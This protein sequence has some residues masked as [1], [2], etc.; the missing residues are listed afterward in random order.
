MQHHIVGNSLSL[1]TDFYQ[2]TMAYGYWKSGMINMESAFHMFYRSPPFKSRFCIACGL[3]SLLEFLEDFKYSS[4]DLN[5]LSGIKGT[6]QK[7]IFEEG[8]IRYLEKF[9]F[10][11]RIDAVKE[12]TVVFP[13]EP[14]LRVQGSLIEGQLLET[15]ILNIINFQTLI[16]TKAYRISHAAQDDP[17]LEFGLRRAQGIDG[18]LSASRAAYIGGCTGTSNVLAGKIFNIPIS[19]TMAH[20]WIMAFEDEL[21]A[22]EVYSAVMPNNCV[23]LVDTYS[24]LSGVMNAIEAGKKLRKKGYQLAAIRLDSG[25][26]AYL[27]SEAR[28]R[29]DEAGFE[30]V[31]IIVSNELDEQL[32]ESLKMQDSKIDAWGVGTKLVTATGHSALNG[33]YKLSAI[34][35]NEEAWQ[36]RIKL[37]EQ[38]IKVTTPGIQQVR[39]YYSEDYN[40]G[41][42]IYNEQSVPAKDRVLMVDPMDSTKRK[43]FHENLPY[44]N[45]L[46]P[47]FY[48]GV[49][50][51]KKEPL[52]KIRDY[53]KSET[54]FFHPTIKRSLN[55]HIYPVGL[56]ESLYDLKNRLILNAREKNN[57]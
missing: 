14:I 28:K 3:G 42:M 44:K 27:S 13:Y 32:I 54:A 56:E 36:Y 37:S 12:G 40:I 5:Y 21:Q 43:T 4:S 10:T 26:L 18:A 41:D 50:Q 2:L 53:V 8:F 49:S 45:L 20:S 47:F 46:Q 35:K 16:A 57:T 30:Q 19:G 34:R 29:L 52:S 9:R 11:S 38:K 25:D 31:K 51:V 7:P 17:V 6:D 22:F 1:L 33:V 15:A 48:N 23:F 55:P 39:R 24:T